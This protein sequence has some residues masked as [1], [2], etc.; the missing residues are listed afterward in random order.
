MSKK[1]TKTRLFIE[2]DCDKNTPERDLT[3]YQN[4][5]VEYFSLLIEIDQRIKR[6]TYGKH[7]N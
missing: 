5:F 6:E 3:N 7:N 2:P 1:T 4:R